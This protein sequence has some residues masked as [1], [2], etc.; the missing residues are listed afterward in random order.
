MTQ[1]EDNTETLT[2]VSTHDKGRRQTTY[3]T[4]HNTET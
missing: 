3:N 4:Q 1:D 2:T